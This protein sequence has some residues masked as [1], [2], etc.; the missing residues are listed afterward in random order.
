M[1]S[2]TFSFSYIN[3]MHEHHHHRK[4]A[5]I[6]R[7]SLTLSC[8]P[9]KSSIVLGITSKLYPLSAQRM[10]TLTGRPTQVRPCL[11]VHNTASLMSSSLLHQ[12]CSACL[13][14]LTWMVCEM[15]GKWLYS[16]C[17]VGCCFRDLFKTPFSILV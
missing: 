13:V 3:V 15:R 7:I 14:R 12:Q 17:F 10:Y 4:I 8:Y 6:V 2:Y 16:C 11:G 9:S 1:N 5:L